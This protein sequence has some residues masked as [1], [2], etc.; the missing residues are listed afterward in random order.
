MLACWPACS[1]CRAHF[2]VWENGSRWQTEPCCQRC[3]L[4]TAWNCKDPN[5][6]ER[7]CCCSC[8][9][10][11][12]QSACS[13]AAACC[14]TCKVPAYRRQ[15]A[16]LL[17][18]LDPKAWIVAQTWIRPCTATAAQG[19]T[20]SSLLRQRDSRRVLQFC[21]YPALLGLVAMR[22]DDSGSSRFTMLANSRGDWSSLEGPPR[23]YT[24][25]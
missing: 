25:V 21:T 12:R 23:E 15:H 19:A 5:P 8:R 7:R 14:Q 13:S 9:P 10:A 22:L 24:P 4:S 18:T 16:S 1:R 3:L 17:H 20:G 2:A 6:C 11:R